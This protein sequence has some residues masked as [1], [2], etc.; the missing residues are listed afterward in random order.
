MNQVCEQG[1]AAARDEY[2]RLSACGKG[3]HAERQRDRA[4]AVARTL[5]AVVDQAMRVPSVMR[6]P[7]GD[8]PRQPRGDEV[9]VRTQT[10]MA[11]FP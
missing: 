11:V 9:T 8:G 3:K 10:R 2:D 6:V 4:H 7:S 1:D 5:D